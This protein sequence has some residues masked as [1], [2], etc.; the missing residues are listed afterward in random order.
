MCVRG[1]TY[2]H[3]KCNAVLFEARLQ[4]KDCKQGHNVKVDVHTHTTATEL[5]LNNMCHVKPLE[6]LVEMK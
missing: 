2:K 5:T 1:I 4:L 6:T 3:I